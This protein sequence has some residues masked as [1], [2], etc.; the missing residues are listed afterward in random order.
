MS[1]HNKWSK[2]KHKKAISDS[3]KSKE[4]SKLARLLTVESK[5]AS[6][7]ISSPSLRVA[8]EKARGAN[9]PSINID[10]AVK[11]GITADAA[12]MEAI[13]YEAYGP[14][15]SALVIEAL[16]ENK[17]KA[18]SEIKHILSKNGSSLAAQGSATWAFENYRRLEGKDTDGYSRR[19]T[20]EAR[21]AH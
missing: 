8:I 17:N 5:K 20:K 18:A 10:R 16:T 12:S 7:D 6:G 19:R 2:I 14:G 21:V 15:G 4:F 3:K 13:T 11:K 1:G 9:M